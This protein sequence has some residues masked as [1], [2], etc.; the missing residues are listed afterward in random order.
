[1]KIT[2]LQ[3]TRLLA[4][5]VTLLGTKYL[6]GRLSFIL[7]SVI[8]AIFGPF[9][10]GW[11]C[12]FG[13]I[14][15]LSHEVGQK[16]FPKFQ[17][18]VPAQINKYLP[19]FKYIF[20]AIFLIA[21]FLPQFGIDF[22]KDLASYFKMSERLKM[23][24]GLPLALVLANFYCRYF[25]W[26]KA[27]FNIMSLV[28]PTAIT[29]DKDKCVGCHQCSAACP[30]K[31]DIPAQSKVKNECVRCMQCIEA[32]SLP[33][34]AIHFTVFGKVVDPLKAGIVY[35]AIYL[36]LIYLAPSLQ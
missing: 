34:K 4:V 27:H 1:M 6:G 8:I 5:G 17:W 21:V 23:V 18:E 2:A 26:H 12:P 33:D 29:I 30:M 35:V 25:C 15:R 36:L 3:I 11:T 20:F 24:F 9:Y 13:T 31:I 16:F 14:S 28:S 22:G 10:C 32:C 19:I 7:L